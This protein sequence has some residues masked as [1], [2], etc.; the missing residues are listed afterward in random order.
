MATPIWVLA[1]V[2]WLHM[3]ATVVW[4]GSLTSL[5]ILVLP[6]ARQILNSQD[7]AGLLGKI[8]KR[9]DPLAWF[10]LLLLLA[11]GMVQM[12]ASPNYKGFLAVDDRW[13][14][15]ILIKHILFAVLIL[16]SAYM[17]W[18]LLPT[19]RR[20]ALKSTLQKTSALTKTNTEALQ[21]REVLILRINLL[22]GVIILALTAIARTS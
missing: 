13:A 8:Q 11:T 14:A 10:S 17:T 6:A 9:L 18:I 12:A 15:A 1:L 5:S 2:Y 3:L 22:L 16:L 4:I 19:L 7:Y 20:Q 21:R